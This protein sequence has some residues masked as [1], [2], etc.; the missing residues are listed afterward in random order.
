MLPNLSEH[1]KLF[2][3]LI[4]IVVQVEQQGT[5]SNV[6]WRSGDYPKFGIDMEIIVGEQVENEL[7]QVGN[8]TQSVA[9]GAL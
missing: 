3:N 9:F 7:Q 6:D 8:V 1:E 5:K 4:K 2:Q